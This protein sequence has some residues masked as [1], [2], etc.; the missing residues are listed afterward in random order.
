M[1]A[2]TSP[3][4][5]PDAVLAAAV[6]GYYGH[7]TAIDDADPDVVDGLRA[8]LAAAIPLVRQQVAEELFAQAAKSPEGSA[9]RRHFRAA[10]QFADPPTP[11]DAARAL[12]EI[13]ERETGGEA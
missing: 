11:Q 7:P 5:V 1:T 6:S 10:A 3:Q 9:R 2:P 4:D 12:Q 13:Y 8:G